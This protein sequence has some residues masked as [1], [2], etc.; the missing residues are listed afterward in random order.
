MKNSKIYKFSV[1]LSG[2][3]AP[4]MRGKTADEKEIAHKA[5][6]ALNTKL[7]GKDVFLKNIEIEKYGRM[8]CDVYLKEEN[9]STWMVNSRL[10]V[11]YSGGKKD[12]P[13]SWKE[14]HENNVL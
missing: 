5:Q 10:A 7:L 9:I 13:S 12:S 3:D 1:R 14:Y 2:I 6:S 8:L 4:E 11:S